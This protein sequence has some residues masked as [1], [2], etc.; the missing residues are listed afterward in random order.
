MALEAA[1]VI[2]QRIFPSK[3]DSA[4]PQIPINSLQSQEIDNLLARENTRPTRESKRRS[5]FCV[6]LGAT[7]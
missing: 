2:T 6:G 3:K 1:S 7:G 4:R 5:A